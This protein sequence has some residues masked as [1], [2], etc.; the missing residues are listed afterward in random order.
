MD[1]QAVLHMPAMA[2]NAGDQ[3]SALKEKK[4]SGCDLHIAL[5]LS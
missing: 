3:F 5:S 1:I 4:V 2:V